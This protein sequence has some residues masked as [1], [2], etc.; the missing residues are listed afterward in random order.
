MKLMLVV[1]LDARD[2]ADAM[3]RI[4]AFREDVQPSVH[5]GLT[6]YRCAE[7]DLR[8]SGALKQVPRTGPVYARWIKPWT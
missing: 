8:E 3:E 1:E 6:I 5:Y 2:E 4:D 7:E